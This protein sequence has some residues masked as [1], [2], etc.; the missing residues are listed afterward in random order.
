MS[1]SEEKVTAPEDRIS[2]KQKTAYALG[3]LVNNLQAAALPAM[4][5]I[6]NIGL[7]MD[8]LWVGVIGS[9]SRIFDAVTD[10]M[11]GYIS[12]NT[13]SRWGR[14]RPYI[15]LGAISAG[16]VFALMWQLPSG[17]INLLSEKTV[18][19]YETLS[20]DKTSIVFREGG[21]VNIHYDKA[22]QSESGV[23][24]YGPRSLTS[25]VRYVQAADLSQYASFELQGEIPEGISLEVIF[26]EAG[27]VPAEGKDYGSAAGDD[28]ESFYYSIAANEHK[29]GI[30]ELDFSDL[31]PYGLSGNQNGKKHLDIQAIKNI[32]VRF[33]QLQGSGVIKMDSIKLKKDPAV[34]QQEKSFIARLV[35]IFDKNA[36][37]AFIDILAEVPIGRHESLSPGDTTIIYSKSG[38][39]S[40]Y[41]T[42][43]QKSNANFVLYGPPLPAGTNSSAFCANLEG[44]PRVEINSS[45]PEGQSL[46][47]FFNEVDDN[48]G[49]SYFIDPVPDKT[50]KNLYQFSLN[51]LQRSTENGN[52]NGNGRPDMQSMKNVTIGFAGLQ[53]AGM[54]TIDSAKLKKNESFFV[55]YFWYFL[56]MSLLFFLAYTVYATPF[57]AFGY[58][59]TSDYHER[60]RLHAFANMVGQIPWLGVSW[61]YA[62][63]A[64][65]LFRDTVHGARTLAIAVGAVVALLG[66]VPA[67][68]C[69]ERQTLIPVK[70]VDKSFWRNMAE[71][72]KGIGI[73]FNCKPFVQICAATFLVF[74]GF[75]L[76]I[77]FSI[78]VMIYYLFNGDDGQGGNLLGWFGMLTSAFT[79]GVIYLT[80]WISRK[81]GKRQTFTITI[82][83][84][85]VGYA[86]KW[87]GYNPEHPYWLLFSAP[88]VAFGTGSLFT[89]MGSMI[90]DICDYDELQTGQRREGVFGA[91]YWW[92]VK[93][94]MALAGLLTGILLKVSGFDVA[95]AAG[96]SEKT[97]F[98]LRVFDVAIPVVTSAIAILVMVSY[99]ISEER[100]HEIRVELERRR[101]KVTG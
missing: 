28:G 70:K 89:L 26:N 29:G 21:Q 31:K 17:Y 49:E 91:I 15:L 72:F 40:L 96:Q 44:F 51:D 59:M 34:L 93:V 76:G 10:P 53:G 54:I 8:A 23:V 86:L 7:G 35:S 9:A 4:A 42:A 36:N 12:D 6:L 98:L 1:L 20:P 37:A 64:S 45:V 87:V 39:T 38:A 2:L 52:Q 56:I 14:R 55:R 95:L 13:R 80:A 101:G 3:M 19:Q 46:R 41:C 79:F 25:K 65:S 92:M 5:V 100:A 90:A 71:F 99:K 75:Q 22:Q 18:V 50:H 84:S 61:F 60:T 82:S 81:I 32:S 67:I 30:L 63:M 24:F 16:I 66:V 48:D 57:V 69:R 77:S 73:T 27:A 58:E 47:V 33:P 43:E 83:L 85:I 88:L 11:L 97:L 68:F 78:Y 74:N 62:I 94:G